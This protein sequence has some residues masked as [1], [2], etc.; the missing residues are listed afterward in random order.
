MTFI[1]KII[2]GSSD[3]L[4]SIK[5]DNRKELLELERLEKKLDEQQK[6]EKKKPVTPFLMTNRM[7]LKFRAIGVLVIFL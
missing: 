2:K 7:S 6:Q 5:S 1:H 3:F 4:K